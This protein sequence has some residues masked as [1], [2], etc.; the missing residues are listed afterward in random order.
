MESNR[1]SSTMKIEKY[2]GQM[3]FDAFDNWLRLGFLI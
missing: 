1:S 3:D 2:Y